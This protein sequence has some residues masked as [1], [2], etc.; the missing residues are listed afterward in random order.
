MSVKDLG[1]TGGCGPK[2]RTEEVRTGEDE[3]FTDN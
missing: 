2:C 1:G 3:D